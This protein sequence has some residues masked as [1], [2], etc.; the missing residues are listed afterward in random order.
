MF[1]GW[2]VVVMCD[3]GVLDWGWDRALIYP[4]TGL[5]RV[6]LTHKNI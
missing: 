5:Q 3:E 6:E 2:E 4:T 1:A